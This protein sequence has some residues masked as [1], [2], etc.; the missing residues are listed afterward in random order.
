MGRK[1]DIDDLVDAQGVADL[2]GLSQRN[3][4]SLYQRRYSDMPRPIVEFR[5]SRIRLWLKPELESWA[6]T[7]GRRL[8]H[9]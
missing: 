9:D 3:T 2:L 1:V 8:I 7:T 5:R 6:R 4:V